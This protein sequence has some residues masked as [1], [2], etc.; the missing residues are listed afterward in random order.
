[1]IAVRLEP[2]G[3][4]PVIRLHSTDTGTKRHRRIR[5]S[6]TLHVISTEHGKP[7]LPPSRAGQPQGRL[8]AVWVKDAGESER[9]TVM[10]WIGGETFSH[11]K[12]GRLPAGL[13]GREK[14]RN[15]CRT[16]LQM[17]ASV[18]APFNASQSAKRLELSI[19]QVIL[20]L[21]ALLKKGL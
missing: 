6:L 17:N 16:E 15:L 3:T 13:S 9:Q 10:A 18:C 2:K 19:V 20:G 12:A 4:W 21:P 1:M 14:S 11:A 7:I 5:R 8:L